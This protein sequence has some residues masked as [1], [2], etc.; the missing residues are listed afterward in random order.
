MITRTSRLELAYTQDK[1][2]THVHPILT[3]H[4]NSYNTTVRC[5]CAAMYSLGVLN[6]VL[7]AVF[8]YPKRFPYFQAA[9]PKTRRP[10]SFL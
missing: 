2:I 6:A 5:V 3:P 7:D 9:A 4:S 1:M 10:R 8:P